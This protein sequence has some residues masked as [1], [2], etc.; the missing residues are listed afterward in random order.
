MIPVDDITWL[1]ATG[2]KIASALVGD[3]LGRA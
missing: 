2:Q 3:M 1:A